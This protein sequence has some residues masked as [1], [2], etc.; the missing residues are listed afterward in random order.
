MFRENILLVDGKNL[1]E[2]PAE[3]MRKVQ[4]FLEVNPS[5]TEKNFV[6]E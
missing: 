2:K 1:V 5:L 6:K 3:E 4:D